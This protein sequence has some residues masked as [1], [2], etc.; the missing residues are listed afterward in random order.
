VRDHQANVP[1]D[2][3]RNSVG[4]GGVHRSQRDDHSSD[5][6]TVGGSRLRGSAYGY[7]RSYGPPQHATER[8]RELAARHTY[9]RVA[10]I[11]SVTLIVSFIVVIIIRALLR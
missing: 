5:G 11:I 8:G 7:P 2:S 9:D 4:G 3:R 1:S 6:T 10:V